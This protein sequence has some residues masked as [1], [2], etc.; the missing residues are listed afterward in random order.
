V[1]KKGPL[2]GITVLDWTQWQMGP[3]A[4]AMLGDLGAEIIHVEHH[5][6]G[7][8]G[9]GLNANDSTPVFRTCPQN[10]LI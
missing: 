10:R 2:V 7:D 4:T 1:E 8:P 6:T 3:V 9:R 5:V